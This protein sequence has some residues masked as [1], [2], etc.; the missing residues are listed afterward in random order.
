[1]PVAP[2]VAVVG[3]GNTAVDAVTQAKRLG[4]RR[5]LMIYRRTAD[6]MP[7][8]EYEYELAK[9]DA[10]EFWW[11]TAPVEIVPDAS[12]ERVGALRCVRMELTA[13]DASGRRGVRAVAGSE[14]EIPV[15]MVVK[16]T[17]QSKMRDWLNGIA[18][19]DTDAT[20]RV[21][22]RPETMQTTNPKIFAGGDCVNGGREAVDAAQTGKLAAQGIHQALTGGRVEFAG[23]RVPFIEKLPEEVPAA[24]PA[25]FDKPA[26]SADEL[27]VKGYGRPER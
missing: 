27:G 19:V 25:E 1:V 9:Q 6:E 11:L 26:A 21:H 20:G 22:V 5:V 7:A 13:A 8:Y 10:V 24:I 2:T 3:A 18:H 12:G 17:G 14:F 23:A 4:A 16:A 15:D